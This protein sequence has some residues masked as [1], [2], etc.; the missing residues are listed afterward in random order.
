MILASMAGDLENTSRYWNGLIPL[1]LTNISSP[2]AAPHVTKLF[3]TIVSA[4]MDKQQFTAGQLIGHVTLRVLKP[5]CD[6]DPAWEVSVVK[7][8]VTSVCMRMAGVQFPTKRFFSFFFQF[9]RA[10]LLLN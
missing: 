9:T 8:L 5:Q 6:L 7:W 2:V 1:L 10:P 4:M 3:L